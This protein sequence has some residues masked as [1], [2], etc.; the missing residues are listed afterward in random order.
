MQYTNRTF[1]TS[2]PPVTRHLLIINVLMYLATFVLQQRGIMDLN[3]WLGLHFWKACDFNPYQFFTYMFMHGGVW[4]LFVN[5]FSLW[6][7]GALLERV[8]GSNRFLLYYIVC[9]LGAGLAQE[10]MWQFTWQDILVSH[11]TGP[12]ATSAQEIIEAINS[13]HA[14]FTMDDFYNGLITIGASGAVFGILLA[15]AMIFPDLPIYIMFVPVPIKAKWA[16]LGYG[17]L[18]LFFGVTGTM[19][20][21]AHY[22]HIGGMIAG[23]F[24]ILYWK[25]NGT[26]RK[27][28]GSY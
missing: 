25:H 4:H 27:R 9:G 7:F 13:G 11:V 26:L 3:S 22:A 17:V 23:I 1:L 28:Y 16:V 10:L 8:L 20:G 18:E 24:L 6:M 12:A 21:I 2:M 19:S 15:F 14:A 5:M